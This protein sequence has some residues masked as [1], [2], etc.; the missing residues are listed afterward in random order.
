MQPKPYM[1]QFEEN[2]ENFAKIT[3]DSKRLHERL[4]V[5]LHSDRS[6]LNRLHD[7]FAAAYDYQTMLLKQ[8]VG[9]AVHTAL[10]K[11]IGVASSLSDIKR[12]MFG[13][14]TVSVSN[15]AETGPVIKVETPFATKYRN[16]AVSGS[17]HLDVAM[18]DY[19]VYAKSGP[20]VWLTCTVGDADKCNGFQRFSLLRQD[21]S[22]E[23]FFATFKQSL[24]QAV[25]TLKRSRRPARSR[26]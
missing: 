9:S 6:P 23:E 19:A 14:T 4:S 21:E 1:Q 3:G 18:Q 2:L 13:E 10:G 26:R 16:E 12:I 22:V 25:S 15:D 17:V 11:F 5:P 20:G 8:R 7:D 24:G